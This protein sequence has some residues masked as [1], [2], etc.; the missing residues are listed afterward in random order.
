MPKATARPK[1]ATV[2]HRVTS[3]CRSSGAR[4]CAIAWNVST[5]VGRMNL[6]ILKMRQASSHSTKMPMVNSHGDSLSSAELMP[7]APSSL[8]HL[9]DLGAQLVHD[10]G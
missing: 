1:P 7:C 6:S 8:A 10:V 2:V 9:R 4:Y 5:G 3:E